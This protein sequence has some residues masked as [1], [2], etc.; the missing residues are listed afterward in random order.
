MFWAASLPQKSER[1]Y[2]EGRRGEH[3]SPM[4]SPPPLPPFRPSP[5]STR[6]AGPG[7]EEKP[8]VEPQ[9]GG[10]AVGER[11]PMGPGVCFSPYL[12]FSPYSSPQPA[13]E[14]AEK[15]S[16]SRYE[17]QKLIREMRRS[18]SDRKRRHYGVWRCLLP[19]PLF[20]L[21]DTKSVYRCGHEE[22]R[23]LIFRMRRSGTYRKKFS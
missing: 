1:D 18:R 2:G 11:G 8:K 21:F 12:P 6:P 23:I 4:P 5:F 16:V 14:R 20:S 7:D 15:R 22:K 9:C 19:L 13:G 17:K 10:S 3:A